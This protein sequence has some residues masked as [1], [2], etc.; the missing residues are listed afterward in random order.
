MHRYD[1]LGGPCGL[2]RCSG[3]APL[4]RFSSA[5][6]SPHR[7]KP[8]EFT[9]DDSVTGAGIITSITDFFPPVLEV[10]V[11]AGGQA[12]HTMEKSSQTV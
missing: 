5:Q 9:T 7:S 3:R 8:Q 4:E 6:L 10:S 1:L 11:H 12:G 2:P